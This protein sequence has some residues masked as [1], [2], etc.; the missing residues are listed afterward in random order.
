MAIPPKAGKKL[1][2]KV[3]PV[4]SFTRSPNGEQ[5]PI[6]S[7]RFSMEE[8]EALEVMAERFQLSFSETVREAVREKLAEEKILVS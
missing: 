6:V 5:R 2:K 8:L 4:R 1:N 7:L 3:Q